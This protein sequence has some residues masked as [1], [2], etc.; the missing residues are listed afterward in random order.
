MLD[1]RSLPP[2]ELLEWELRLREGV[3]AA[4]EANGGHPF[5]LLDWIEDRIGGEVRTREPQPQE[6]CKRSV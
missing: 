2:D 5:P 1:V 4:I 6:T 3:L